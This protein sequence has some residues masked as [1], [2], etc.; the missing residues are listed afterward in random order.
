MTTTRTRQR[1]VGEASVWLLCTAGPA[2][3]I[4]MVERLAPPGVTWGDLWNWLE[5]PAPEEA[6]IALAVVAVRLAAVWVLASTTVTGLAM[7]SGRARMTEAASRFAL[8][9]VRR[10]ALATAMRVAAVTLAVTPALAPVTATALEATPPSWVAASAADEPDQ[11]LPPFLIIAPGGGELPAAVDE[12]DATAEEDATTDTR[13]MPIPP[14]LLT[15]AG[16]VAPVDTASAT[17]AIGATS[18][19]VVAGD[20]LWAIAGKRLTDVRRQ[21]PDEGEH[22]RY[23]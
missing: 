15:E 7:L 4:A 11:P 22:A 17:G 14:F 21:T 20:H 23:W 3:A 6:M 19:T 5:A 10:L 2:V 1:R 8:P 12:A 18:Y 9:T 13:P 16:T